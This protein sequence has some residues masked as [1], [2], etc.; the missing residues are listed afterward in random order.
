MAKGVLKVKS[1]DILP[2]IKK[3]LYSDKDIFLREL[4]SNGCDAVSKLERLAS[5]GEAEGFEKNE[6]SIEIILDK[7]N[8]KLMVSDN[9]IGMTG[10]EIEKYI[11]NLAFSGAEEFLSKYKDKGEGN[12]IIG[13]FGLGFYSAFMV[14]EKVEIDSLSFEPGAK[15][16]FWSCAGGVEYETGEGARENRGTTVT[17][18]ISEDNKEFLDTAHT[19]RILKKY[20]AFLPVPIYL[21]EAGKERGESINNTNPLW[22]KKPSECTD[23]EYKSFYKEVFLDFNDPLFWIHLNV[24]YPF[25]LKGI[26]YFPK[27]KSELELNEGQIKLYSNQVFVA[28]NIK[29]VIPEFL[30]LLKG[31]IDCADLPLNVSRSFLQND[32]YVNRVSSHITKKVG[33]KLTALFEKE[34]GDFESYWDDINPFIKFGCMRDEK[35]YERVKETLIFK[36]TEGKFITLADYPGEGEKTLYYATDADLQSQYIALYKELGI[37]VV[38]LPGMID[39]HFIQFLEA[40]NQGVSFKRV[41]SALPGES[42]EGA[43]KNNDA[44]ISL[45]KDAINDKELKIEAAPLKTSLP[46]VLLVNEQSRRLGEMGRL[47]GGGG[48]NMPEE[49]TLTLNLNNPIIKALDKKNEG[50]D[51][52]CRH[53]YDLALLSQRPLGPEAMAEFVRRSTDLLGKIVAN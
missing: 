36:T 3:W 2:V 38:M 41:D 7:E 6:A 37:S 53:V 11:T 4:V 44:I 35:F 1:E 40:K 26:L 16:A 10:D 18:Y 28:D 17:L 15:P 48:F 42:K 49:K 50:A 8:K 12:E 43:G 52:I 30:L 45:F 46:A 22:L 31:C 51:T 9:G 13:H 25:S 19:G 39:A 5:L 27:L 32:G 34:R 21:Y 33:D 47:F 23:E 29:E 24:D 14:A 20:C